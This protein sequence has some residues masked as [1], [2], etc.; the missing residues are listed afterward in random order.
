M[1]LSR[2]DIVA[3]EF[4][5]AT[6][7]L[8]GKF[9]EIMPAAA[10]DQCP[11][12]GLGEATLIAW[13]QT[14]WGNFTRNL[15]LTSAL[16]TR[17]KEASSFRP[18][19]GVKSLSDAE[20]LVR[21]AT[22]CAI[23]R[24]GLRSPAWHAPSFGIAVSSILELGNHMHIELSLGSTT[25]PNMV[26]DFRNYLVHPGDDT[27][28]KYERLQQ[29]LGMHYAEPEDLLHQYWRPGLPVFTWWV[30]ELQRIAH[31]ATR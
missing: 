16:G 4:Q 24:R 15:I 30:R 13:L 27:R 28:R 11:G 20:K 22:S 2:L 19:K 3:T 31:D 21:K 29:K 9:L 7:I 6:E 8:H 23:E 5:N 18:M 25:V 17:R 26:S 14:R 10:G 1:P 12:A